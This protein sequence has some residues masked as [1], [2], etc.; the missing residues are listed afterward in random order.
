MLKRTDA[1]PP[2]PP[3]KQCECHKAVGE[4][5]MLTVGVSARDRFFFFLFFHFCVSVTLFSVF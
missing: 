1:N 3:P 5:L 4:V 2:C